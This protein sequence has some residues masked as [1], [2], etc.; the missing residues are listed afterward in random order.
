V[1]QTT[2]ETHTTSEIQTTKFSEQQFQARVA[3]LRGE[4]AQA[5]AQL[6]SWPE[7]P[8]TRAAKRFANLPDGGWEGATFP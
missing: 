2:S 8:T 7:I 1:T 5:E 6:A 4:L 3:V